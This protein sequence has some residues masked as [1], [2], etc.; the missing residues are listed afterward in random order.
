V[1]DSVPA[2]RPYAVSP[3]FRDR[4]PDRTRKFTTPLLYRLSYVGEERC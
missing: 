4:R 3:D 2:A 1:T